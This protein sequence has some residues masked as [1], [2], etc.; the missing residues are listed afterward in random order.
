[1][2]YQ[3]FTI[4]S[5]SS[6]IKFSLFSMESFEELKLAGAISGIGLDKGLFSIRDK[7]GKSLIDQVQPF[8]NH[9]QALKTLFGWLRNQYMG[10]NLDAIGHRVVHGGP[11][12]REHQLL[13]AE[14]MKVLNRLSPF[15]PN[16]LPHEIKGIEAAKLFYPDAKEIICFDTAFHRAMPDVAKMYALPRQFWNQGIIR[17]GFHGLSYEYIMQELKKETGNSESQGKLIIAHLGQGSSMVA[18]NQGQVQ[19]TTMGFTPTEGLVMGTRSGD[20]DPGVILYLL[21]AKEMNANDIN[22][23]INYESGLLGVSEISSD[24]KTLLAVEQEEPHAAEAINLFCYRTRK[25]LGALAAAMGGLETVIFTGG[26]GENSSAI[27]WQICQD[28]EFLGI[29]LD[30]QLNEQNAPVISNNESLVMVR[31]LPTNEELMIARHT[32][33]FIRKEK[34]L[35]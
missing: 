29:L 10:K 18:V 26:I 19:D 12:L 31:V 2:A 34:N 32:Y 35:S 15:I 21:Q 20:L 9:E 33:Q 27:R 23:L 16:H 8:E 7:T 11:E 13:T 17:Y 3:I 22:Q 6:S 1:M 5:G 24:M 14:L 4:N 25:Y 30:P 28:L